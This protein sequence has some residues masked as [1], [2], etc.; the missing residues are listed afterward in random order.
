MIYFSYKEAVAKLQFS[1]ANIPG[2]CFGSLQADKTRDCCKTPMR[3]TTGSK[4]NK[5]TR[6]GGIFFSLKKP[7]AVLVYI[8]AAF[9]VFA[10]R[11]IENI[12]ASSKKE[13][14]EFK[15]VDSNGSIDHLAKTIVVVLPKEQELTNLTA[16]VKYTGRSISPAP[17]GKK[18]YSSGVVFTVT[19]QDGSTAGYT[20]TV[21]N[22]GSSTKEITGFQF[23]GISSVGTSIDN[24]AG[25]IV[26]TLPRTVHKTIFTP[27]VTHSGVKYEPAGPQN[28]ASPAA[29]TVTAADGSTK[30]YRVTVAWEKSDENTIEKFVLS[31][32]EGMIKG[33][34]ITVDL[35]YGTDVRTIAPNEIVHN[36]ISIEPAADVA[37]NFSTPKTYVVT[38][39]KGSQQTYTVEVTV[40]INSAKTIQVFR[41]GGATGKITGTNIT[42]TVPYEIG[43]SGPLVPEIS[44]NGASIAPDPSIEQDFSREVSYIVT[45]ENGAYQTYTVN[46][47]TA[48]CP[49]KTITGFTL[50]YRS[51]SAEGQVVN[52]F[53]TDVNGN[54]TGSTISV[55]IP[56]GIDVSS[57]TPVIT[58]PDA[59]SVLPAGAQNFLNDVVY[60][61]TAEDGTTQE[62]TVTVMVSDPTSKS[63]INFN[64][65]GQLNIAPMIDHG[66]DADAEG[67]IT[68]LMP[69][70][71]NL[72]A[73]TPVITHS[74]MSVQNNA[75]TTA[76]NFSDPNTPV[77]YT[78]VA[79]NNSKKSYKVKITNPLLPP[80]TAASHDGYVV[81]SQGDLFKQTDFYTLVDGDVSSYVTYHS[82]GKITVTWE[83]GAITVNR[84]RLVYYNLI[85][86]TIE[87]RI[88]GT[89]TAVAAYTGGGEE[90]I[91]TIPQSDITGLRIT[92]TNYQSFRPRFRELILE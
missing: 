66:D 76:A 47:N 84:L 86:T 6:K 12:P 43:L 11:D 92:A 32:H 90:F 62:Y 42:V 13:I 31:N 70:R 81:T 35:P 23:S 78:V 85:N 73:L 52:A 41:L 16:K 58:A 57:L 36:G 7:A 1:T 51:G 27:V 59:V 25:T 26:I 5:L 19:A 88:A 74:G 15:L 72:T 44:H 22:N 46:A 55:I 39:E 14:I 87:F 67:T 91:Q 45:A 54:I 89:W 48:L 40:A 29:S 83:S 53:T 37:R 65:P 21:Q 77:V 17:E 2:K 38:S 75:G 60:T 18:D 4:N 9:A 82:Y 20:V 10:C 71:A 30:T 63:I 79:G 34:N 33:T 80:I 56:N 69:Q 49:Y 64:L 61:V 3:F 24:T 28:F 68:V 8:A 50:P